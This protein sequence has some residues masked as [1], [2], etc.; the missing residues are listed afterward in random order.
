MNYLLDTNVVI[1]YSKSKDRARKIEA[2]YKIFA[3]ENNLAI[4]IVSIAE[5][6][7]IIHQFEIGDKR[8]KGIDKILGNVT[9]LDISYDEILKKYEEIDA[10]SRGKHRT[11]KSSFSAINMGK[12]DLWIAA[13]A[14]AFNITLVTTDKDFNHL[15]GRFIEVEFIDLTRY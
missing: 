7:S 13:T 3:K 6:N 8:R 15:N 1:I 11:I 12:N 14:S 4:S 10:Y 2:D 5:I 9:K